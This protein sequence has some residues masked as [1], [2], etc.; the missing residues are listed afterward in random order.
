MDVAAAPEQGSSVWSVDLKRSM[1]ASFGAPS[2]NSGAREISW[3]RCR[4]LSTW[5]GSESPW[6]RWPRGC[7]PRPSAWRPWL[8]PQVVGGD[9]QLE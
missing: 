8:L 4:W 6:G 9:H 3:P 1:V 5:L 7:L 2:P